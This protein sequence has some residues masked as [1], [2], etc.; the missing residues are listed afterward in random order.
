MGELR[1]QHEVNVAGEFSVTQALLALLRRSE[2]R[3][4]NV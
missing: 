1:P 4:N 2:G 3:I